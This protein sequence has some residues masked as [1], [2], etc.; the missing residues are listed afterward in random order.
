[1]VKKKIKKNNNFNNKNMFFKP[2]NI[3]LYKIFKKS[4]LKIA[5]IKLKI[6]WTC[7]LNLYDDFE[8]KKLFYFF[9]SI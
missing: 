8:N 2:K 3:Y 7:I 6:L 1:M 5:I 4:L 9:P